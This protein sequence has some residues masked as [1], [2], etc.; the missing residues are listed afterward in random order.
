MSGD[1]NQLVAAV[2]A[3]LR[4]SAGMRAGDGVVVAVSGGVDSMVLLDALV[5][6]A[7]PLGLRLCVAHLDH[8]MRPGSAAD[9]EFVAAAAAAHG[10]ECRRGKADVP[11][12]AR[13]EKRSP[14]EAARHARYAFLEKVRDETG[15]RW[16]ALG[17]HAGDQAETVLL[18]LLRGAGTG[19]LGAMAPVGA[20]GCVRPL[21]AQGRE[22]I[23]AYARQRALAFR[24]D[25]TN[26]D[27]A[28]PR[29]RIRHELLPLLAA[30]YNPEV[31]QALCRAADILREECAALEEIARTA[32]ETVSCERRRDLVVLAAPQIVRYH[33]AVQR[34]LLRS[35]LVVLSPGEEPISFAHLGSLT[36]LLDRGDG[37]PLSLG[38][39]IDAQVADG[40]LILRRGTP[41]DFVRPIAVPG[42]TEIGE[43]CLVVVARLISPASFGQLR[44]ALGGWRAAFDADVAG[45]HLALR[46]GREGDRL[47]PLGMEG[48]KK[49]SDLFVDAKIPRLLR[50]EHPVV[51]RGQEILWVAGVRTAHAYRVR[52]GSRCV[53]LL[54]ISHQSQPETNE[55]GT[56]E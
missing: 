32:L 27:L 54:E 25:E 38:R 14:E 39:G 40:R 43:R 8:G 5:R 3:A 47:Q 51:T 7:G 35:A 33:I 55:S 50:P 30:G 37:G 48:R 18:H 44:P 19:G 41:P 2:E 53:L 34:H 24:T 23:E 11:A 28:V 21:L 56:S 20:G 42:R 17:H 36:R 4:E 16:I 12:L 45:P 6:L 52:T 10:L 29:N 22:E 26:Q 49:V 31:S 9:A 13:R 15:S 46:S 1:A